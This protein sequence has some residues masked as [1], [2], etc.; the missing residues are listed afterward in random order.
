MINIQHYLWKLKCLKQLYENNYLIPLLFQAK[1]VKKLS[2][3]D[4]RVVHSLSHHPTD[5][6][7]LT[8]AGSKIILWSANDPGE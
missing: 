7:L 6:S 1:V 3:P 5:C 2:N 4:G 8:A